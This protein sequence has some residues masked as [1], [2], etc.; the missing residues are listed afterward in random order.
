M[1][2][3]AAEAMHNYLMFG[4]LLNCRI[5]PTADLHA[6]TF[7]VRRRRREEECVAR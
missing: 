4:Q 1:A 3:I 5:V 2:A 7:K 6:E